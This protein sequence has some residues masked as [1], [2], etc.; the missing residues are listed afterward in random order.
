MDENA[1]EEDEEDFVIN[2]FACLDEEK[3]SLKLYCCKFTHLHV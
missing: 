1:I 3:I 2:E